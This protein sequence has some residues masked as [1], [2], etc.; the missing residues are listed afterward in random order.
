M[1]ETNFEKFKR[2]LRELFMFDQADLDFGIYRIMN[3]KRDEITAFL[4]KDLLPQVRTALGEL[5][6]VDHAALVTDLAKAVEKAKDLGV[7]PDSTQKVKDLR[8]QIAQ[9][10]DLGALENE[11]FSNLYVFFRRYYSEGDFLS[12]RRYKEG[13]YAIPYEGEEVKLYWANA[14]QYY[15]KTAEYFRDYSFRVADGRRVHFKLFAADTL[16]NNNGQAVGQERRFILRETDPIA[17]VNGDLII[18]FEYRPD[19]SKRKQTDLNAESAKKILNADQ[20]RDWLARL[21]APAP[22]D[23][24]PDRTLLERHLAD[25]TARNTFDYFIHKNLGSF[26]RR[27]LDFFIKNEVMHLDDVQ[28]ETAPRVEQYL[29]RIKAIRVIAHKL[30]DFLA[31][32]ENFEK[33]LWLKKKFVIE[34]NYCVTLDRIPEELYEEVAA[35]DAQREEWVRLIAIDEIKGDP[36]YSVPLTNDFLKAHQTL[37]VD[38]RHFSGEFTRRLLATIPMLDEQ[39]DG[40][41]I[42]SEN[43]QAL[44]LM[45]SRYREQIECIHIDPPYNT[46]T[47][48]FLYKNDYQ[49]SSWLAMMSDRL[50]AGRT[51]LS[52]R[53]SLLCHIDENENERLQLLCNDLQLPSAGTIVWDKKNPMLGRKGVATQHEYVLWRTEIQEPVYLRNAKQRLILKTAGEIIEKHGGVT[54]LAESE[55][56]KWI[57]NCPGLSGGERAYRNLDKH[58]RVYQSA[59]MSA[60]E[61][62]TDPK[63][64]VPLIHPKTGK[65]CPVPPFGWSRSPETLKELVDNDEII[66]GEDESVQPRRKLFL[67]TES[68]RQVSSVLQD[69]NRG[70]ADVDKLGLE[71]PYCHPLS[72]YVDLVGAAAPSDDATVLDFFAG[73]GTNGHAVIALNRDEGTRRRFI[74]V[75]VREY[76]DSVLL[77]RLK[78]V[79][80]TP[81]WK[82][83]KPQRTATKEEAERGPHIM[84]VLRLESYEDTLDNIEM[85]RT[86]AQG[87]LLTQQAG[88]REDFTLRY[89]LDVESQGSASLLDLEQF[90][91]P[92]N[93]KLK[94]STASAGE[95]RLTKVD[96]VETF[97]YLLGL[98]VKHIDSIR[99]FTVVQGTNPAGEKTLVIWR[100]IREKSSSELDDFFV[101]QK[102]NTRDMEFDLI[103][104]N[105][106]NN[107]ENLKRPDETWKVRLI[108]EEFKRLM[109]DVHDV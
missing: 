42:H 78:K 19:A 2:L 81:E 66:F 76:F 44:S 90:E 94:V 95:S 30:I 87:D 106:D 20:T 73:S 1:A 43:F 74:L 21:A 24:N 69:A 89:M 72:L 55:F 64:F 63:F 27:E 35:N 68:Q 6:A 67:T 10:A 46:Q 96:L 13:V 37:T 99:G 80:Y 62:R 45:Q 88:L 75:E 101:K 17:Q 60:P 39:T 70:K 51:L 107:L 47:S 86:H 14:D 102:Y 98:Q 83:G 82:D 3:S 103:Y 5:E 100:N 61:P 91:D 34:T 56:A 65:P 97:T 109:F 71:F 104:V 31:Q 33:K 36:A 15:I 105:G 29:A 79:T 41:F 22:T 8:Q 85:R 59:G 25:Y 52:S 49:H 7:D 92:F 16:Q 4:E 40:V 50:Q 26:L 48:G 38:T 32:L 84:K 53:G 23:K 54:E 57:S 93:Y 58:G 18:H 12:L 11:I 77:P 108:E 28:S 9:K